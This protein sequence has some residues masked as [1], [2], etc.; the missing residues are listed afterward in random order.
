MNRTA[1]TV[2]K[3][4]V[5]GVVGIQVIALLAALY[6]FGQSGSFD[7]V[8]LSFGVSFLGA[9]GFALLALYFI[10][11]GDSTDEGA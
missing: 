2:L 10:A 3:R 11:V 1:R 7:Y 5:G 6:E 8:Y 9:M 4:Y